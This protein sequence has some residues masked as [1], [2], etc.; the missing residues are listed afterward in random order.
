MR[1]LP[2]VASSSELSSTSDELIRF[3]A[4]ACSRGLHA[5]IGG[6]FCWKLLDIC[7]A[8]FLEI[9]WTLQHE[10]QSKT[11]M[12]TY[13]HLTKGNNVLLPLP[14]S[15]KEYMWHITGEQK[16]FYLPFSCSKAYKYWDQ[17]KKK[18]NWFP[19]STCEHN[20]NNSFLLL[21]DEVH[22]LKSYIVEVVLFKM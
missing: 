21:I 4:T 1:F 17:N 22:V 14:P 16:N 18:H 12:I 8:W 5:S 3:S 20:N 7:T 15:K 11:S 13:A 9:V 19:F 10:T 2:L 6:N